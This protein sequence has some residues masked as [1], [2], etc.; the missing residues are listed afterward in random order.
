MRRSIRTFLG[1]L[2]A[3]ALFGAYGIASKNGATGGGQDLPAVGF[4]H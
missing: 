3:V 1:I 2:I 4:S